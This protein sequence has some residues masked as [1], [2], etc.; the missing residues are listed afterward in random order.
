MDIVIKANVKIIKQLT[1]NGISAIVLMIFVA[2]SAATESQC[3]E[4]HTSPRKLIQITREIAKLRPP[5]ESK[6][7]GPG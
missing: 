2:S 5:V 1:I 3:V 4:C 7:K 6:S